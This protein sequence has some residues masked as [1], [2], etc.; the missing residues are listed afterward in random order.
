MK[1]VGYSRF[2]PGQGPEVLEDL[3]LPEPTPG[4]RDLLVRV[5]AVAI[6][7]RDTKVRRTK[8]ASP[9]RPQVLGWDAAG[10]VA[11]VG[12][13]VTG[14]GVGDDVYYAGSAERPGCFSELHVVDE[15]IVGHKPSTLDFPA[16]AALPLTSLTAYE[17]LFDRLQVPLG[18]GGGT[19]LVLGGAGGVPSMAI[20]FAAR[21]TGL[22]VVATASREESRT[23]V[24]RM[25]AQHVVDHHE[26]LAEQVRALG[27]GDHP[28]SYAFSTHTSAE[29]WRALAAMAAPQGRIGLID[30]PEPLDL[31]LLKAKSVSVHWESMYTRSTF[32][33]PDLGRQREILDTVA[34]AVDAGTVVSPATQHLGTI[35]AAGIR[36]AQEAIEAGSVIGKLTLSG[37]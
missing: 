2:E 32:G 29:A 8:P 31:R 33:T 35:D 11:A 27:L 34:D 12:S 13:E 6:N 16:A 17:M 36:A 30:D 4:P 37:F 14:Y 1:A 5:A 18:E 28:I 10:T 21:L 22:T 24:Q 3:T 26:D 15:R 23:W 20:Q 25:G 19:L 7:P 9:E